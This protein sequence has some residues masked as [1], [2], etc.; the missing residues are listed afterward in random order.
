MTT[1]RDTRRPLEFWDEMLALQQEH[2]HSRDHVALYKER[3]ESAEASTK[4]DSIYFLK[5]GYAER[6]LEDVTYCYCR[7]DSLDEI[8]EKYIDGGI[9][10][11]VFTC[12]EID[13]HR[14]DIEDSS[15]FWQSELFHPND[16]HS[17]YSMMC[18]FVCFEAD[19]KKLGRIAPYIAR[20]GRDRLIDT[21][22]QKYQPDRE[23]ANED[24]A[25][26]TFKL[27]QSVMDV[28]EAKAIKNLEKYLANWGKL[29]GTLK[30]LR[31]IGLLGTRGA[32]SN[33]SLI[34]NLDTIENISYRGF[35]AWEVALVVRVFGIDDS[36]FCDHEFYPKDLAH[37]KP[38]A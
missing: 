27:L 8:K 14:E 13:K 24:R 36:S 31:S 16:I 18:W 6:Y 33:E 38:G 30:G 9:D 28:D 19:T 4:S 2:A 32:K 3:I 15:C 34:A 21:I 12:G 35:W 37:Y 29:M 25:V 17:A 7:G 23:I 22:L 5:K 10:R 1:Q 20:A 26:R 11:Y